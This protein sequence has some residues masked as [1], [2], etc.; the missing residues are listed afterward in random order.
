M[1]LLLCRLQAAAITAGN[2]NNVVD[3][4]FNNGTGLAEW[5]EGVDCGIQ[6]YQQSNIKLRPCCGLRMSSAE[7]RCELLTQ[8]QCE[9]KSGIWQADKLL[10]S[11]TMCF[12][13][14]CRLH[15]DG[16]CLGRPAHQNAWG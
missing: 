10:C 9:V 3:K 16:K 2:G 5:T 14:I 13:D 11:D 12:D 8:S 7:N 6:G 4:G 15:A 1:V